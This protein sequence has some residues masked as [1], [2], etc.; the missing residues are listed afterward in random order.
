MNS[1]HKLVG[2]VETTQCLA[3]VVVDIKMFSEFASILQKEE[4]IEKKLTVLCLPYNNVL[5]AACW[6][7]VR[8]EKETEERLPFHL[9]PN[10]CELQR[11]LIIIIKL[12]SI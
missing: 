6:P 1:N 10:V 3:C 12:N 8:S 2:S 9:S 5:T 7:R 4:K 11:F